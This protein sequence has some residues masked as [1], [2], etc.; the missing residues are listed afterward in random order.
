MRAHGVPAW[1][2]ELL[3]DMLEK[4]QLHI[5]LDL[6]PDPHI[7]TLSPDPAMLVDITKGRRR[8]NVSA[9]INLSVRLFCVTFFHFQQSVLIISIVHFLPI[10]ITHLLS[11]YLGSL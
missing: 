9:K 7:Q 10:F 11:I 4:D 6:E 3:R 8:S 2:M 5:A 1:C